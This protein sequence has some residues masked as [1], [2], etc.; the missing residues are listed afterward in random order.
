LPPG[1]HAR[2]RG[3]RGAGLAP[4]GPPLY[5]ARRS[6]PPEIWLPANAAPVQYTPGT[7]AFSA[8]QALGTPANDLYLTQLHAAFVYGGSAAGLLIA[9]FSYGAANTPIDVSRRTFA[10]SDPAND[11]LGWFNFSQ[12]TRPGRIPAGEPAYVR[13]WTTSPGV[14]PGP[15]FE[16]AAIGF[17]GAYP[18]F[19]RL[20]RNT[21][22]GA[23]R[24]YPSDTHAGLSTVAST[25]PAWGASLTVVDPA[26]NDMLV[27]CIL[28]GSAI[29]DYAGQWTAVQVGV[30][31]AGAETWLATVILAHAVSS[32]WIW[33]PV[34]AKAGERLAVRGMNN[35]RHV[36]VKVHDL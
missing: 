4:L 24:I 35:S 31:P 15:L 36:L 20:P 6:N 11:A 30:G 28:G 23:G 21:V 34:W 2:R 18:A 1:P 13:G 32:G 14:A 8:W 5:L 16:N 22:A 33:P 29:G 3:Q 7:G 26:P 12:E 27:T 19:D 17:D 25:P 9:E 10:F